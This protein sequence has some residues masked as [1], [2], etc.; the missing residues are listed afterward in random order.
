MI[1][2]VNSPGIG[3]GASLALTKSRV[4]YLLYRFTAIDLMP[5]VGTTA[6]LAPLR[7]YGPRAGLPSLSTVKPHSSAGRCG[8]ADQ[9]CMP[10]F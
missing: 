5:D 8:G 9:H 1:A 6:P 2:T 4:A 7:K 3:A 10:G